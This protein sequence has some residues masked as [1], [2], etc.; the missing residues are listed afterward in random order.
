MN[1]AS[2][3]RRSDR[4]GAWRPVG[5]RLV[6]A[7]DLR[8]WTPK[9]L[10]VPDTDL[11]AA[12][13]RSGAGRGRAGRALVGLGVAEARHHVHV[14]GPTGT[15]KSTLLL[16]LVLAEVAAGRGVV[17]IDPH[18]DLAVRIL[19]RLPRDCYERLVLIDPEQ[20]DAPVS[21]N[22]LDP[23]PVGAELVTEHLVATLHRLYAPWW[24][25]RL[26]DTLRAACLTLT[27]PTNQVRD[28]AGRGGGGDVGGHPQAADPAPGSGPRPRPG[29]D[30]RTR[31]GWAR[32][33]TPTTP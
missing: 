15:G 21:W 10:G 5:L 17:V 22:V 8:R 14:L 19:Q 16:R 1:A 9:P 23:A 30:G 33:G 7:G 11:D 4:P 31:V 29:C 28:G 26:E 13:A 3:A 20:T 18:G 2:P 6:A 32:S 27:H 12:G 24:G 25:P